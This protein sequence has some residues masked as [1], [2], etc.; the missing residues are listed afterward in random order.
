MAEGDRVAVRHRFRGTEPGPM[1]PY[2]PSG[3]G[4]TTDYL[5]I[6]RLSQDR[7]VEAW[8]GWDNLSGLAQLGHGR[9][10]G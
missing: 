4:M 5:T 9:A 8:A 7:I 3:A 10:D 1:G 6:Y 2:S